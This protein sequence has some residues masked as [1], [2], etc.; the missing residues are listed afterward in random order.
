VLTGWTVDRR[1]RHPGIEPTLFLDEWHEPGAIPVLG[2]S[3]RAAGARQLDAVLDDLASH[4]ATATHVARKLVRHFVADASPPDLV[5][6]VAQAFRAS[7]G[8]LAATTRALVTADAAWTPP[9]VKMRSPYELCLAGVRG[10]GVPLGRPAWPVVRALGQKV[11]A[12]PSPAGF[13]D[14]DDSWLAGDALLERLDWATA[15]A[16]AAGPRVD[17]RMLARDL[18]GPSLDR[19]TEVTIARAESPE[20][21]LALLLMSP[22][23]QRR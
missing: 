20:Q 23:F 8:D 19:D 3:Y 11:W 14:A 21:A 15:Y 2:T 13:P 12:P 6:A 17:A 16:R 5:A 4:P 10:T 22:G 7:D 9:A 18:L 1:D